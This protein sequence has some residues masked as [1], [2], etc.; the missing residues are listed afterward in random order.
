M[1]SSLSK[2]VIYT[3]FHK[4]DLLVKTLDTA[5]GGDVDSMSS[6]RFRDV[7]L[8]KPLK[9]RHLRGEQASYTTI[10]GYMH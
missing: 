5:T 7:G 6:S 9:L 4:T 3:L 2:M 1:A 10:R 8:L